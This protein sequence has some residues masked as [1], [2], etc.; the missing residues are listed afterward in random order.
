MKLDLK[1]YKIL[2]Q[3][4]V[5]CRQPLN[6]IAKKVQINKDTLIYR[7]KKL[8][9]ENIVLRYQ[10]YINHGKLGYTTARITLKL[11][12]TT[13]EIEQG[14]IE[15]INSQ[16]FV[17]FFAS[18]EGSIDL[19]VWIIVKDIQQINEFWNNITSR[20]MNYIDQTMMG[21]YTKIVHYPRTYLINNAMNKDE[22][23]F[24]GSDKPVQ[25][26]DKDMEIIKILT[27]NARMPLTRIAKKI[28]MNAKTIVSRIKDLEQRGIITGYSAQI[29][30][31]KLGYSYFKLYFDLQNTTI[32]QLNKL[33]YFVLQH[34]NIIYRDHV[35]TGHACEIEVQVKDEKQ[36]REL[37]DTMKKEFSNII[38]RHEVLH[39]YKEHKML[40]LPWA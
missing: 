13:P 2:H 1:D 5:N 9:S 30:I 38:K 23:C 24:T 33:D 34:P 35:I 36:L 15:F 18:V 29:D 31:A 14:I 6:Q 20:F 8:E 40:S 7:I 39:Y 16:P 27:V 19:I 12:N 25:V 21:I 37:I 26:D 22:M 3:L 28:H 11:Q 10:A 4:D 32:E 17:G